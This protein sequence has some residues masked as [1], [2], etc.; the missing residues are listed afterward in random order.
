MGS[1]GQNSSYLIKMKI[2]LVTDSMKNIPFLVDTAGE[3]SEIF[4]GSE[5]GLRLESSH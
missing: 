5:G 1:L 2:K 3:Y 4:D